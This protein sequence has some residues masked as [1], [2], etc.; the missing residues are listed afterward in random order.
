VTADAPTTLQWIAPVPA[1]SGAT[2]AH[3]LASPGP[4]A[5]QSRALETWARTHGLKLVLPSD[6][7]PPPLAVDARAGDEVE[8]LLDRVRD[9]IAGRDAE[10]TERGLVA[11][12]ST[13][14]AHPE[15][16]QASW[17]MAEVERLRSTRF[18]RVPP[19]DAEAAERAWMRAEALD[20]GRVAGVGEQAAAAHPADATIA[21][22]PLLAGAT[23]LVDGHPTPARAGMVAT[24]A[25][26]HSLAVTWDDTPVWAGWIE[27]PAGS[28]SLPIAVPLPPACSIGDLG[29][30]RVEG[31]TVDAERV[32]CGS[33]VA[34]LA[35][36]RPTSVLVALCKAG[37]CGPLV[38]WSTPGPVSWTP[39][40]PSG[41]HHTGWPT[42]ATW[43]LVGAGAVVATGVVL[44]ASGVL[45]AAP[46]ETRFVSGGIKSQ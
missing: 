26:P 43:G 44:L 21:L 35:G 6:E 20:G 19:L 22:D 40:P 28:S 14:R 12:E 32:R 30:A 16:P 4:D 10:A 31:A 8:R 46:T 23:L 7:K 13:L 41:E 37:R 34:G 24:H 45:Q 18:R 42:W 15:L 38:E 27:T 25:G 1:S 5:E 33:W 9:A 29:L 11:A 2:G 36:P 39:Q 17:L 3:A